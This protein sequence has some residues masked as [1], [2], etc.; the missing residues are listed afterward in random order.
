[1]SKRKTHEE[2]E[3]QLLKKEIDYWPIE[4]YVNSRTK[5]L[6]ECIEGHQWLV[7]PQDI[8]SGYGCPVCAGNLKKTT[9]SYIVDLISK[10]IVYRPIESYINNDTKILHECQK[11]HRWYARPDNILAGQGCPTCSKSGF[12]FSKP[13]K[14]Y[15]FSFEQDEIVYYKIGITNRST[16]ERHST[17]WVRLKVKLLW[18][19]DFDLGSEA[20]KLEKQIINDNNMYLINT[21]VLR[22]GNTETFTVYIE[23]PTSMQDRT[24]RLVRM[25]HNSSVQIRLLP[26]V[27]LFSKPA[28]KAA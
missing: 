16:Q 12:D 13:A 20:R 4:R 3:Q 24:V 26:P 7:K 22:S 1:M 27:T 8:L 28:R 9:E 18:E 2:Y 17:D 5:I 23:P 10:G 21:G 15:F 25:A 14:L 6:H 11:D 19:L